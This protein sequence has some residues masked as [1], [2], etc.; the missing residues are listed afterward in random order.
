MAAETFENKLRTWEEIFDDPIPE[1]A[2]AKSA[3]SPH[4]S[5][6]LE[7]HSR[8]PEKPRAARVSRPSRARTTFR[9]NATAAMRLARLRNAVE[10][11]GKNWKKG[12]CEAGHKFLHQLL[13][14]KDWC[15][16]CG[17]R[18]SQAHKKRVA[19]ILPK[20]QQIDGMAYIVIEFK[21]QD[22]DT[23]YSRKAL[24]EAGKTI[25]RVLADF[26]K[27]PCPQCGRVAK[28]QQDGSWIC[29]T[30]PKRHGTFQ[31]PNAPFFPRGITRWHWFGEPVCPQAFCHRQGTWDRFEGSWRCERHGFFS[32]KD[33]RPADMH[34]HPHLNV[35][36][37][38]GWLDPKVLTRLQE[39]LSEALIE[40]FQAELNPN[41]SIKKL[42]KG[43]ILNYQ[44]IPKL[45]AP[46]QGDAE[47]EIEAQEG[48]EG[49][50]KYRVSKMIHRAKYIMHPTFLAI[51]WDPAMALELE[52]FHATATY[53]NW[54][55][56]EI[57][58]LESQDESKEIQPL[59]AMAQGKCPHDDTPITWESGIVH[60]TFEASRLADLGGGF[61]E[62]T[63]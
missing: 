45:D 37:D 18:D 24:A 43:I 35:L 19:R 49:L 47:K 22:R 50:R 42:E 38:G 17:Q 3:N 59:I 57:F 16:T 41:G 21:N 23:F 32:V 14:E 54:H 25:R 13:C 11:C 6:V 56:P 61:F 31:S 28:Q 40:D 36:V 39:E 48:R 53:G 30:S 10:A 60:D 20:V 1:K 4:Y 7:L 26:G 2:P 29:P 51:D 15:P 46:A 58:A 44:Y 62:L 8:V 9:Q 12:T 34:W 5:D 33:V 55:Q 63:G 52:D 27:P